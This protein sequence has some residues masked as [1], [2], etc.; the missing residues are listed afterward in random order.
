MTVVRIIQLN[1]SGGGIKNESENGKELRLLFLCAKVLCEA[2]LRR[3]EEPPHDRCDFFQETFFYPSRIIYIS[4]ITIILI[5]IHMKLTKAQT[6]FLN[7]YVKGSWNLN[8]EGL[9]DVKG[10]FDCCYQDL[11]SFK[12]IKF[13]KISGDFNCFNNQLTSLE[14]A[15]QEVG[16]NFKCH[17]NKLTSLEGAPQKVGDGFFCSNNQLTSLVGAPQEV[18]G[19]FD[20]Y[21]NQLTSLVGA[22]QKA[23]GYFNCKGNKLTS[24]EGAPQKVGRDFNCEG[25]KLTSLEGAPQKVGRDFNCCHNQLT[26]LEG[27]PQKVGGSFN[28]SNN[29]LTSLE[30]APQEVVGDFEFNGSLEESFEII[31]KKMKGGI[32]Y[33]VALLASKS[34]ISKDQWNKL[35]KRSIEGMDPEEAYN[36]EKGASILSRVGIF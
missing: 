1:S 12:R 25:N 33:G 10:Y 9:V 31:Y 16:G 28:C 22:P 7:R 11:K 5:L 20:C 3:T 18:E 36:I 29:Q 27:A 23:E 19:Y 15:P 2:L 14:G 17:G 21:N 8:S 32:P 35:D 6:E 26:S 24:L 4:V 34:K 13:G 30:G